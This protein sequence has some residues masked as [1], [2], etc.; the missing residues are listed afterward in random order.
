MP[1][2]IKQYCKTCDKCASQKYPN[3]LPKAPLQIY[4]VGVPMER[5]ALDI[6]GPLPITHKKNSYLLVVG[7]YFTKWTDVIPIKNKTSITIAQKLLQYIIPIFG[8]PMQ[9][10]SD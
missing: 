8:V 7:D 5:W 4:N 9:L 2:D 1:S 6:L 10:H 3:K